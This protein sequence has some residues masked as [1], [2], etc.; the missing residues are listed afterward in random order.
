MHQNIFKRFIP[1]I[2]IIF[3]LCIPVILLFWQFFTKGYIPIPGKYMVSWY[4]PWKS[5]TTINGVP[6]IPHKP[7]ADDV[8]RQIYPFKILATDMLARN[9]LPLW[10]PY[11]GSG[12][13]FLATIHTALFNPF[14]LLLA[15]NNKPV[16]WSWYVI[17]QMI[18]VGGAA[19]LYVSLLGVS[20]VGSLIASITLML[21][22]FMVVRLEYGVYGYALFEFLILFLSIELIRKQNILGYALLS[23]AV[24]L[25]L[26]SIQPQLFT[27]I[28][29]WTLVYLLVRLWSYKKRLFVSI[30]LMGIGI[31]ISAAQLLPM[32]ELYLQ[33]NVTSSSSKFIFER[34]LMPIEHIIT[35]AIPNYFGN[36]ATYNWWGTGD[37]TQTMMTLGTIPIFLS[38][39]VFFQKK[40]NALVLMLGLGVIG[41]ILITIDTPITRWAYSLPL[42]ILSTNIPTRIYIVTT[43]CLSILAGLGFDSFIQQR[44]K[45]LLF[46]FWVPLLLLLGETIRLWFVKAPCPAHATLCRVS[47]VRTTVLEVSIFFIFTLCAL[48]FSR[49]KKLFGFI[50]ISLLISIGVYNGWKYLPMSNPEY[51]MPSHPVLTFMKNQAPARAAG[52]GNAFFATDFATQYRYFDTNYYD[53][54]YIRRYGELVSYVNTGNRTGELSRSDVNVIADATVSADLDFRRERFWDMTGTSVLVT[55]KSDILTSFNKIR[56]EDDKWAITDR[57]NVFPRAYLVTN[58]KKIT[59]PDEELVAMFSRDTDLKNIAFT[60]E[61]IFG[62]NNGAEVN[63]SVKINSY[64]EQEIQ[65][66]VNTPSTAFLVLSDTFYPGWKVLIDG[67]N[68]KIY[69]TNFT[70]RGVVVPKGNHKVVWYYEPTIFKLGILLSGSSVLIWLIFVIIYNRKIR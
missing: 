31:A 17:M 36:G 67:E 64:K 70:F 15:I 69:R 21:S 43:F 34:F 30:I 19:F 66:V 56:W 44:N 11:N 22:G 4:E 42:P 25:L 61:P 27:Y 51:V 5:D 8:F 32:L 37:S 59:D 68:S 41:T 52:Y 55:K 58:V 7:I 16:G 6:T 28:L 62:L 46:F 47:A 45:R 9:T 26:V 13:P 12:Q 63:G 3:V 53:P 33:A 48:L 10:N 65:M 57:P 54:L 35:F 38:C 23:P 50:V 18:L 60:E 29:F 49:S 14:S 24:A 20:P 39:V 2:T 1:S 40:K